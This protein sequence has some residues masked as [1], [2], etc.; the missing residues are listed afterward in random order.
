MR[1]DQLETPVAVVDLDRLN[2]NIE[3]L[4]AYLNQH[5][6]GNRP[7]IKTHKIPAIAH[8]QLNAGAIGITV[9]KIAE[10]EVMADAGI[11]DMFLPYNILGQAKLE[12]LMHLTRR[13]SLSVSA[14]S[15]TTVAGLAAA[16]RREGACLP[17][18]V[19]FDTGTGRCGVQTPQEAADLALYIVRQDN[20]R[21]TGV[22]AYPSN[23]NT[24]AFVA[25]L[26]E[27][28]AHHGVAIEVVSGGGS[29]NMW[30][31]HAY[32]EVTEHRA[33]TYVYG[34]RSLVNVG[35][36][37][38]DEV[39]FHVLATVVSRPTADR[40]ILDAGSKTLTSDKSRGAEGYGLILE[41]PDAM[42]NNLSEEHG[43]VDL[44]ACRRKPE[45]GE[46]VTILVNH[47]CVVNN[48]FNEVVGLRR[49]EVEVVWPVAARGL[50]T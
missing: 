40:A 11:R 48:M 9:Q 49:G 12:R 3:R 33:G 15:Q 14:D 41:Y 13:V 29:P 32:K 28:L 5:R 22:M 24:D 42:I 45:I 39:S 1:A 30:N 35:A 21:F 23:E 16:A 10:A 46:R 36:L 43:W 17:V 18:L 19:E 8:M 47:C 4:Q 31:A 44:S 7:H 38:Q 37:K 34:D 20:L 6:I 2:A 50:L 25:A 26:R 27:I